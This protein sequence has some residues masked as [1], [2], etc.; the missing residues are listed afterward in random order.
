MTIGKEW[1][2]FVKVIF[3]ITVEQ[4]SSCRSESRWTE[5]SEMKDGC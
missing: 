1:T 2:A 3:A 4:V 5:S